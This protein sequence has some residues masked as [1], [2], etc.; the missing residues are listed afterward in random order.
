MD[1]DAAM[2]ELE[3]TH[4]IGPIADSFPFT[5]GEEPSSRPALASPDDATAD[6][7]TQD[8]DVTAE[9]PVNMAKPRWTH[10]RV[11][12]ALAERLTRLAGEMLIAHGEGRVALPNAMAEKVPAWFVVQNALDEQEARRLRSNRPRAKK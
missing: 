9:T 8:T 4:P 11:P 2:E 3:R 1:F 6:L 5:L 10:V 7:S 12:V